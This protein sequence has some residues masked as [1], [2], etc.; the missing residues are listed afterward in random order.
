MQ[1]SLRNRLGEETTA[2]ERIS[3]GT[4]AVS[5]GDVVRIN[6]KPQLVGRVLH[7]TIPQARGSECTQGGER[8][9]RGRDA[10]GKG[11]YRREQRGEGT[12]DRIAQSM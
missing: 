7:F 5:R 8:E 2:F 11:G 1:A 6:A 12:C 4:R 10:G 9:G 3:D